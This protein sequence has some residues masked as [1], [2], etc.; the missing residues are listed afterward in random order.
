MRDL[1]EQVLD[2][3]YPFPAEHPWWKD[4]AQTLARCVMQYHEVLEWLRENMPR[5]LELCPYKTD[6]AT[7]VRPSDPLAGSQAGLSGPSGSPTPHQS[8]LDKSA[9]VFAVPES[10][11]TWLREAGCATA[12][13][14]P[15]GFD[16]RPAADYVASLEARQE[17]AFRA[18]RE[19]LE[20]LQRYLRI[21]L[22][23]GGLSASPEVER[24]PVGDPGDHPGREH[25]TDGSPCWCD[26]ERCDFGGGA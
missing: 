24:A 19:C 7:A 25:V 11:L 3:G 6:G 17:E 10:R 5:S 13:P 20:I 1:A 18:A 16:S 26:P 4:Q 21:E 2:D 14:R 12:Y 22:R 9:A 8:T 15:S 23:P